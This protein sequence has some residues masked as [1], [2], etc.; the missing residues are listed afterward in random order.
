[1]NCTSAVHSEMDIL[2]EFFSSSH[3]LQPSL[4][5]PTLYSVYAWSIFLKTYVGQVWTY[6]LPP[7][8]A[9]AENTWS[10]GSM[11]YTLLEYLEYPFF[12]ACAVTFPPHIFLVICMSSKPSLTLHIQEM[13]EIILCCDASFITCKWWLRCSERSAVSGLKKNFFIAQ[14]F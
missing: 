4:I 1:M 8:G 10:L 2:G 9:E 3:Y 5:S 11:L 14:M 12:T 13:R 7:L 6:H